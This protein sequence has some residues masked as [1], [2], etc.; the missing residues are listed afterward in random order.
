M[1]DCHCHDNVPLLDHVPPVAVKVD[2]TRAVPAIDG[3]VVF[4]GA[5]KPEFLP[6][7]AVVEPFVSSAT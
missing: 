7:P 4:V 1:D 3:A 5:T 6:L 2:A